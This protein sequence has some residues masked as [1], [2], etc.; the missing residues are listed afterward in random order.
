[1]H[2]VF[3]D[4]LMHTQA[5]GTSLNKTVSCF[6]WFK[7]TDCHRAVLSIVIETEIFTRKIAA[8]NLKK[9]PS[10]VSPLLSLSPPCDKKGKYLPVAHVFSGE[11]FSD[12][13]SRRQC[14]VCF[15]FSLSSCSVRSSEQ[16]GL[17]RT[18]GHWI[19]LR[20]RRQNHWN[21]HLKLVFEIRLKVR[22]WK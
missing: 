10:K 15:N 14:F 7:M 11:S 20:P 4:E 2:G 17:H 8:L 3:F 6:L 18:I 9:M 22:K 16:L 5:S 12:L 21:W 19:L 13:E 1:M